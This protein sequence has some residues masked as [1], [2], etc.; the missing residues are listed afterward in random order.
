MFPFLPWC[1]PD[2]ELSET[3]QWL[4]SILPDWE[5]GK[6]YGFA[7]IRKSDERYLGGIGLNQIDEN[8][9]VNLG[10]W[11]RSSATGQGIATEAT[12]ALAAFGL[13]RLQKI[14][15]EIIMSV[16]NEASRKVAENAGAK[17]EGILRNRLLLHGRCHDAHSYSILRSDLNLI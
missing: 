5:D 8:P 17:Y 16:E 3:R 13:T 12:R 2:Y 6:S 14:R 9:V 10:Y 7:I 4:T 11:I 15:V 1:H